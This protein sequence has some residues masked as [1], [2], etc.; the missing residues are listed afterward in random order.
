M[1]AHMRSEIL[2][3]MIFVCACLN[4]PAQVL[5]SVNGMDRSSALTCPVDPDPNWKSQEKQTWT[6][7]ICLGKVADLVTCPGG[8]RCQCDVANAINWS[9]AHEMTPQFIETLLTN[10]KYR[11]LVARRG[12][13]IRCAKFTQRV[14]LSDIKLSHGLRIEDSFFSDGLSTSDSHIVGNFSLSGSHL[15]GT[16]EATGMHVDG[17]LLLDRRANF[18]DAVVLVGAT[19]RGDIHARGSYFGRGLHA[20][21][22]TVTGGVFLNLDN[23]FAKKY[24]SCGHKI[25]GARYVSCR[26]TVIGGPVELR[27]AGIGSSLIVTGAHFKGDFEADGLVVGGNVFLNNRARFSKSVNL[28]DAQIEGALVATGA[29]F[30]GDFRADR[31]IVRGALLLR[32]GS[33]F[34]KLVVL[35]GVRIDNQLSI[36]K[37]R[38]LGEFRASG[39]VAN[40]RFLLD[41]GAEFGDGV[42]LVDARFTG[43]VDASGSTFKGVLEGT[44][45][46]VGGDLLFNGATFE[47]AAQLKGAEISG[48][49]DFAGG[50]FFDTVD[51]TVS[52]VA[53]ILILDDG[54]NSC[55]GWSPNSRILLGG[56][57]VGALQKLPLLLARTKET[58]QLS[59]VYV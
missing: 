7:L 9:S 53:G 35:R 30:K 20:D 3:L 36:R 47:D 19:I 54:H 57:S 43:T 55:Q 44:G 4:V 14:D 24:I 11:D 6:N 49:L 52:N 18:D 31:M 12:L 50:K 45:L 26:R 21:R 28:L 13:R 58:K 8:T 23:K 32:N 16:L 56:A 25:F 38:F 15:R 40:G 34:E 59:R 29:H 46:V 42:E 51:L 10:Q 39:L 37:S 33:T 17:N 1:K 2:F 48:N 27:G 22:S 41:D 5:A